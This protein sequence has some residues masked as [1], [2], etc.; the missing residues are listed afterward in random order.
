ML[1]DG[2]AYQFFSCFKKHAEYNEA[3][4]ERLDNNDKK[5][6]QWN[7]IRGLFST[8]CPMFFENI[9]EVNS[10][11]DIWHHHFPPEW[12]ITVANS[13]K[14]IP[15]IILYEFY[16]W[17]HQ[18]IFADK[19]GY[20]EKLSE[21]V[22]GIFPNAHHTLFPIFLT[23]LFSGEIKQAIQKDLG[24]FL[25]NTAVS[26]SGDK[27]EEEINNIVREKE[28]LQ[29]QETIDIIF[30]LFIE[31][32]YWGRLRL[33]KDDLSQEENTNWKD[34]TEE[35]QRQIIDR[36]RK[37]KFQKMLDELENPEIKVMCK[38]SEIFEL[39]RQKMLNLVQLLLNH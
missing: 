14:N 31:Y 30:N 15:R 17:E 39:R 3:G 24:V 21:V 20:D 13:Q 38:N 6:K 37:N 34:Y 5:Q 19:S 2:E 28:S 7:Y 26:W 33:F 18:R 25:T 11:F 9:N 23:L 27:T 32:K 16:Q 36:V 29:R 35:K 8:F 22:Q 1:H 12:K 10:K 4:L